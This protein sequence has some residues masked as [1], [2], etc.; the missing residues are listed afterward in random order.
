MPLFAP[1]AR[2]VLR[3]GLA[4]CLTQAD[5]LICQKRPRASGEQDQEDGGPEQALVHGWLLENA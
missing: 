4:G 3:L 5:E 1:L 2:R